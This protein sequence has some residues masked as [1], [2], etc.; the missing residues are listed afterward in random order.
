MQPQGQEPYLVQG[1]ITWAWRDIWWSLE[2]WP[3]RTWTPDSLEGEIWSG[4]AACVWDPLHTAPETPTWWWSEALIEK[5]IVGIEDPI[6]STASWLWICCVPLGQPVECLLNSHC[7]A[8]RILGWS[9]CGSSGSGWSLTLL[10]MMWNAVGKS[11]NFLLLLQY[12][13]YNTCPTFP[14][15]N[16]LWKKTFENLKVERTRSLVCDRG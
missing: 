15:R 7:F 11:P 3:L 6:E 2:I 10:F 12:Q 1:H 16:I 13:D 9:V 8:V 5:V 4:W 14:H